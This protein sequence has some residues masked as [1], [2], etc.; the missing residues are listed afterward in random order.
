MKPLKEP[1][2][3]RAS[4]EAVELLRAWIIDK[5]LQCSLSLEH[6]G[7]QEAMVWGILLSDIARHVADGLFKAQRIPAE[8]T[9]RIIRTH[10]D[11]EIDAPTAPTSGAFEKPQ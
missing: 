8:E 6:F 1:P 2:S 3:A 9:L 10:F 4:K 7:D 5:G 11:Q